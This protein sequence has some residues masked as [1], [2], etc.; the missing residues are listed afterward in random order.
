MY[1]RAGKPSCCDTSER[2]GYFEYV[3]TCKIPSTMNHI[4]ITQKLMTRKFHQLP[5][6]GKIA[7]GTSLF[8]CIAFYG[9]LFF[10]VFANPLKYDSFVE[11]AKCPACYGT[12]KCDLFRS[13]AVILLTW[14]HLT[15][16]SRFNIKNVYL[17]HYDDEPVILKRL[18]RSAE[19]YEIDD[20][21][22]QR[23]KLPAGCDVS[24]AVKHTSVMAGTKWMTSYAANLSDLTV[25][26]SER[27][28]ER[29]YDRYQEKI[30]AI[31][32]SA[33]EKMYLLTTLMV[34]PEPIMLQVIY[35]DCM[36][37][38]STFTALD[39]S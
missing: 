6:V 28:M 35:P 36:I 23:A 21:I 13:G 16:L 25:C 31:Q 34:N 29:I 27:L 14:T 22:C 1:R 24:E 26:P 15:V 4:D 20:Q 10:A 17:G 3:K 5:M 8:L 9:W 18:G 37:L 33:V 12:S 2:I 38:Y 19:L 30:D 32:L 39:P 7:V 11:L